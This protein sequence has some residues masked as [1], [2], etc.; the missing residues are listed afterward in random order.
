MEDR[1]SLGAAQDVF[2]EATPADIPSLRWVSTTASARRT[3][4]DPEA[5]RV[6]NE[7]AVP[8][9]C[10]LPFTADGSKPADLLKRWR[11]AEEPEVKARKSK[12]KSGG[13]R[14]GKAKGVSD[15]KGGGDGA[16]AENNTSA[17]NKA[18]TT[19]RASKKAKH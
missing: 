4:I 2:I 11:V 6:G 15:D 3:N 16:A 14:K 19:T 1:A 18:N 7:I 12:E 13:K 9:A 10:L 5:I 17:G 8:L